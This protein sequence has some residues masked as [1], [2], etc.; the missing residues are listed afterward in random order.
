LRVV[1]SSAQ[2]VRRPERKRVGTGP[3]EP[4]E[5]RDSVSVQDGWRFVPP[6]RHAVK[7]QRSKPSGSR[8]TTEKRGMNGAQG[9]GYASPAPCIAGGDSGAAGYKAAAVQTVDRN[10]S[11]RCST[12]ENFE[13]NESPGRRLDS[14]AAAAMGCA[15]QMLCVSFRE[16]HGEEILV[17][18][19]RL[20]SSRM[21]TAGLLTAAPACPQS[22]GM[23]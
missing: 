6:V 14:G 23:T 16:R 21:A 20:G 22:A 8:V 5:G 9:S 12:A 1:E 13:K 18:F 3:C 15:A 4:G 2:S 17:A 7:G 11:G 19:V 10:S